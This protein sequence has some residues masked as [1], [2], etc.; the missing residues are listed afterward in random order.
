[1]ISSLESMSPESL[2][3]IVLALAALIWGAGVWY[4]KIDRGEKDFRKFVEKVGETFEEINSRIEDISRKLPSST[5]SRESPFQLTKQG[6][7]VAEFVGAKAWAESTIATLSESNQVDAIL[8]MEPFEIDGF[9]GDHAMSRVG[10]SPMI[11]R[12]AYQFGIAKIDVLAVMQIVLR[13]K[14]LDLKAKK[15]SGG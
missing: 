2:I 6:E 3:T 9:S 5:I 1:M 10:K 12:A 15:S 11:A 13:D 7:E 4:S 14:L 8:E